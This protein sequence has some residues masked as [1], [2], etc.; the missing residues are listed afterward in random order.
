MKIKLAYQSH[1]QVWRPNQRWRWKTQ[2]VDV[3]DSDDEFKIVKQK[4]EEEKNTGE[5][6]KKTVAKSYKY[7]NPG[8]TG[9]TSAKTGQ[10]LL[11]CTL[12]VLQCL[13]YAAGKSFDYGKQGL[14]NAGSHHCKPCMANM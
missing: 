1:A 7:P 3:Y 4:I 6:V 2:H 13:P 9:T 8:P 5:D 14:Q 10:L 12:L 11:T